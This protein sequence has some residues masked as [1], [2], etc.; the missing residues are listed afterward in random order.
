VPSWR[1]IIQAV[2]VALALGIPAVSV[3][4]AEGA[5][6]IWQ[7][8]A[9]ET[10][11]ADGL[12]RAADA[13]WQP[14]RI[15]ALDGVE[16]DAWLMT[17]R[18]PNGAVVTLLHGV[19]DTRLGMTGHALFLLRAGYAV[20]LTDARGHGASGG[21]VIGYGFLEASDLRRWSDWLAGQHAD[22]RQHGLGVSMGAAILL[23][24][25]GAPTRFRS[26][27]AES[28]F[29]TFEEI[30]Y[31]R[32][33]QHSGL[34]GHAFWPVVQLGFVYARARYGVDLW[35]VSPAA[36]LRAT[37]VPVLL[38]HGSRDSNIPLHH[39]QQLQAVNRRTAELWVVP[40]AGHVQ[41]LTVAGPEYQRRVLD[42]FE[43]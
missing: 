35:T 20:L 37:S 40:G 22:W 42:W 34:P 14:A 27:V 19:G 18:H 9:V 3:M 11:A 2:L 32:M 28:P 24:S 7:R 16:L 31:D 39:S 36:G 6:H 33:A 26:A 43:K 8:P 23:E 30:A 41:C 25:L 29:D 5:L 4:V 1:A 21:T 13:A 12:A 38:I 15:R 17:P 10:S